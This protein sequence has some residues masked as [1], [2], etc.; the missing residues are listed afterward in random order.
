MFSRLWYPFLLPRRQII[1]IRAFSCSD[2]LFVSP[3]SCSLLLYCNACIYPWGLFT[4]SRECLLFAFAPA[5]VLILD[6][7]ISVSSFASMFCTVGRLLSSLAGM[8]EKGCMSLQLSVLSTC[9][10]WACDLRRLHPF[11]AVNI[12]NHCGM[13][14]V[15]WS[16][17]GRQR[18]FL[19]KIKL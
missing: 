2:P 6:Q 16:P 4:E 7:L 5:Q 3:C 17:L 19:N 13:G 14:E 8:A 18:P 1:W 12:W 9:M 15:F 11:Y 10:I